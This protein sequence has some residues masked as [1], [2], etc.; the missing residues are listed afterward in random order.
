MSGSSKGYDREVLEASLAVVNNYNLSMHQLMYN[1]IQKFSADSMM[2]KVAET[3]LLKPEI[4]EHR[5]GFVFNPQ[6]LLINEE[7]YQHPSSCIN[8]ETVGPSKFIDSDYVPEKEQDIMEQD[9]LVAKP[10]PTGHFSSAKDEPI[11]MKMESHNTL[12]LMI[13]S[14]TD[15]DIAVGL[16]TGIWSSTFK[17]NETLREAFEHYVQDNGGQVYLF[18]SVNKSGHI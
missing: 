13:K 2:M 5:N 15:F 17:G 9:T 14:T 12:F 11:F 6:N 1:V 3:S 4:T 7:Q 10:I 16:Q 18:F 8:F